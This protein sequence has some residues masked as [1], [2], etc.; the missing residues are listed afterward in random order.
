MVNIIITECQCLIFQFHLLTSCMIMDMYC[1]AS[2]K[3]DASG[4]LLNEGYWIVPDDLC[5][6]FMLNFHVLLSHNFLNILQNKTMYF[7]NYFFS[8]C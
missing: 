3:T 8:F 4:S 6:S 5:H 7:P 2:S 1:G